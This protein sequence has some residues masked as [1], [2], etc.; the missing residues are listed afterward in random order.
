MAN[1]NPLSPTLQSFK[2]TV[3]SSISSLQSAKE[4]I[5]QSLN[6]ASTSFDSAY[7]G[8]T[9]SITDEQG[10]AASNSL[11]LIMNATEVLK[12]SMQSDMGNIL[13]ECTKVGEII[14]E[15]EAKI[16]E[17]EPLEPG[18]WDKVFNEITKMFTNKW[19]END[20]GR[21]D[22]LNQEIDRLNRQGEAQLNAI[23][24]ASGAIT[25]GIQGNMISG[26]TLGSYLAFS[27]NYN[28]S[29]EEWEKE[30]PV[31]TES[32]LGQVGGFVVGLVETPLNIVEGLADTA[33]LVA[34][35]VLAIVGADTSGIKNWI[36]TDHVG[37]FV[38]D[39]LYSGSDA[40]ST[41]RG[42]GGAVSDFVFRKLLG[43]IPVVRWVLAVSTAGRVAESTLASG[44]NLG[45]ATVG[46]VVG[47]VVDY[48]LTGK[49]S[50]NNNNTT[51]DATQPL[52]P[53][54]TVQALP[55]G[56]TVQA[57]PPGKTP[58]GLPAA[59]QTT[60]KVLKD[61]NILLSNGDV[62]DK[63]GN[64]LYNAKEMIG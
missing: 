53:G 17:G 1:M 33:A 8:I 16:K 15:I 43:Q 29:R 45:V 12:N 22:A 23:A 60:V 32:L 13:S 9:Q 55:S 21:I 3:L 39:T 14:A 35:D 37:N 18:F 7:S 6:E 58:L 36:A 44:A 4:E 50:S 56:K 30:N 11:K 61:G 51:S 41:A 48:L 42:A 57:L 46:G 25:L 26:G 20:Q 2:D 38:N 59:G 47:G 28:F 24:G 62:V 63:F 31:Y 49:M 64:I 10:T 27:E 40:Y 54:E 34:A 19:A 52:S 5:A